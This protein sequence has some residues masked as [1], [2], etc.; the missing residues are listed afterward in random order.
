MNENDIINFRRLSDNLLTSGQPTREQFSLVRDL[1]CQVVINL[2]MPNS[3]GFLLDELELVEG[4]GMHYVAIPIV[5]DAPQLDDAR[6]L[7]ETLQTHSEDRVLIHCAKNMRVS[8]L[9][10]LYRTLFQHEEEATALLDLHAIWAPN[11]TWQAYLDEVR[12][13]Y[14]NLSTT[15]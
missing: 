7:F 10:F 14:D 11:E 5:W 2:A 15:R 8:A 9:M 12:R 6:Q 1:G 4:L 3:E 13:H